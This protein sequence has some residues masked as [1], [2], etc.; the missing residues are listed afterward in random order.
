[1]QSHL[2]TLYLSILAALSLAAVTITDV[3]T[4]SIPVVLGAAFTTLVGAAAGVA[5]SGN[6]NSNSSN[7]SSDGLG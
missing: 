4:G 3:V 2:P 5:Y 6:G 7:G 1:M